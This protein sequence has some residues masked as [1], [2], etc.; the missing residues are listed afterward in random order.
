MRAAGLLALLIFAGCHKT[1]ATPDDSPEVPVE[2]RS[3]DSDSPVDSEHSDPPHTGDS[4]DSPVTDDSNPPLPVPASIVFL[5]GDVEFPS[6]DSGMRLR[7]FYSVEDEAGLPIACEAAT[8]LASFSLCPDPGCAEAWPVASDTVS[9]VCGEA[10]VLAFVLAPPP[11]EALEAVRASLVA[12]GEALTAAGGS[13]TLVLASDP[14]AA[15][16]LSDAATADLS[17]TADPSGALT[18][19]REA[20]RG[21][22][23][24]GI[25]LWLNDSA[26]EATYDSAVRAAVLGGVGLQIVGPPE[27]MPSSPPEGS[28]LRP[29]DDPIGGLTRATDAHIQAARVL[30][31]SVDRAMSCG[32]LG[33]EAEITAAGFSDSAVW[34]QQHSCP[35]TMD[36]DLFEQFFVDPLGDGLHRQSWRYGFGPRRFSDGT[37]S[38]H[39]GIDMEAPAGDPIYAVAPGLVI[40]A[41]PRESYDDSGNFVVIDH[42]G[43]VRSWYLHMQDVDVSE[44][45]TVARGEHIGTVGSS[46]AS[47]AHLHFSVTHCDTCSTTSLGHYSSQT[48]N[49][50]WLLPRPESADHSVSVV[51]LDANDPQNAT[52]TLTVTT[53][54]DELDF[55]T[56]HVEVGGVFSDTLDFDNRLGCSNRTDPTDGVWTVEPSLGPWTSGV[57]WTITISPIDLRNGT[58]SVTAIA[59]DVW[60]NSVAAP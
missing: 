9:A 16:P 53:P 50:A 48:I 11:P 57:S 55:A 13:G 58:R 45:Q 26:A 6:A 18:L 14:P 5:T 37:Y 40:Q 25:V 17:A 33:V 28:T 46:G 29:T 35:S 60:G 8:A 49:P 30:V 54:G 10:P 12:A 3:D 41:G 7:A 4:T 44:G 52:L 56:L 21:A 22:E 19:A 36:A 32:A 20:L 2:S 1:E 24:R 39:P 23:N 59:T 38:F 43:G 15:M 51:S 47:W 31:R 42:G 27:A 34:S